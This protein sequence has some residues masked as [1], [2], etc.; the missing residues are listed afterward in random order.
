MGACFDVILRM[1]LTASFVIAAVFFIRLLLMHAPKRY[2]Y[3]L[4]LVV[5]I[6]LICPVAPE[7]RFGVV[8]DM[9]WVSGE[10]HTAE[11][12]TSDKQE[13]DREPSTEAVWVSGGAIQNE[14]RFPDIQG[15][16][17]VPADMDIPVSESVNGEAHLEAAYRAAGTDE[18][19]VSGQ[20][21][22]WVSDAA[23]NVVGLCWLCGCL[24]FLS[25]G[26]AG[27]FR[28]RYR[29]YQKKKQ[30][31]CID[32]NTVEKVEKPVFVQ[33]RLVRI[34]EDSGIGAPFTVGIFRPV[35][36]LPEGL[37]PFQREMVLAHESVHIR[38]WDNLV[39]LIAYAVRC[40][41]WFNPLVWLA[42]RYFEED[43]ETSCDEAVLR[44]VGYE[45]R[46]E[47]AKTLLALSECQEK[48]GG[49]YPV[50]FG[51]KNAKGRIRNVLSA[52]KAGMWVV[53][54][55]AAL[56]AVTVVVLLADHKPASAMGEQGPE[57]V[58]VESDVLEELHQQELMQ[59]ELEQLQ[60]ELAS[61]EE[62]LRQQQ[63][64]LARWEAELAAYQELIKSLSAEPRTMEILVSARTRIV[65]GTLPEGAVCLAD[66]EGYL[67]YTDGAVTAVYTD[68]VCALLCNPRL[69]FG[70]TGVAVSYSF[71][72][73]GMEN[74]S[75]S[76]TAAYGCRINPISGAVSFH[77]GIDFA[78]EEGTPVYAVADACVY[79][80]GFD[81]ENG[82]YV[83]LIHAN[84]EVTYY[85]HCQSV[86]VQAGDIVDRGQQIATVGSTGKS[87]GAHLHFALSRQGAFIVPELEG[88]D[89][90]LSEDS[91]MVLP[92]ER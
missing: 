88:V 79:R 4:W 25:Y 50:S 5:L 17:D 30:L 23:W 91:V 82:N 52:K 24:I 33:H 40:M 29:L 10:V 74:G 84:D 19:P 47:Y 6:R 39:K 89:R 11:E 1:S 63:E 42:F 14:A 68:G 31:I 2:S 43:M 90:P 85:T 48:A 35:V 55:S 32:R 86:G 13:Y 9:A 7:S 73:D 65:N 15:A 76:M 57:D 72:L 80:T 92:V 67:N 34:M 45:R 16:A 71:P 70:E 21:L 59:A 8:P 36:C 37:L 54:G 26:L 20:R 69:R 61:R 22:W 27:Y 62:E 49:F 46:K 44:R 53:L 78:A 38:R 28:L 58:Q 51:R 64:E 3:V 18:N 12:R 77:S 41:H 56:V 75:V 66:S 81:E 60:E 83:I 87:T